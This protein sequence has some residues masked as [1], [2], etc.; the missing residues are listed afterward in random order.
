MASGR[1]FSVAQRQS[2]IREL[3]AGG[4]E[5]AISKLAS[6]FGVSEMTIRRDLDKLQRRGAVRRTHGGAM[7]AERMVFEFNFLARR[8]ANRAA[9]RAIASEAVKLVQPG[10]RIILDTGTTTLELALLLKDFENLTVITPS[11]AVASELQFTEGVQTVLLGGVIRRG[12][13]DLTGPVTEAVLDTFAADIAF[14]GADGIGLDG[15][16]YNADMRIGRVDQKIRQRAGK[17][18]IL[19]D[20]SK[21]G[22]TALV[23]HGFVHEVAGLITDDGINT[24]LLREWERNGAHITVVRP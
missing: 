3:L 16:I 13:P 18:Y 20:S 2:A 22:R 11:L 7:P 5:L 17:T 1:K 10:Q 12:S 23:R 4:K 9:K 6:R 24:K 14:Q 15:A 8:Q 21:I 19:S